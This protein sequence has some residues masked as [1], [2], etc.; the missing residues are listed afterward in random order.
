MSRGRQ[1]PLP[2]SEGCM[3]SEPLR[4]AFQAMQRLCSLV[5]VLPLGLATVVVD[6]PAELLSP[7]CALPFVTLDD[8]WRAT[9]TGGAG[10][11]GGFTGD[12]AKR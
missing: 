5:L 10:P 12:V 1:A 9:G 8:A 2:G 6:V 4:S 7:Q 3:Q 11:A